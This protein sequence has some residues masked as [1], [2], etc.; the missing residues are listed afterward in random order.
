MLKVLVVVNEPAVRRGIILGMDWGKMEC[1]VAAEAA[2]GLEGLEAA[3][4]YRPNLII[5]DLRMPKMDGLEMFCRLREQGYL[6]NG[7]LLDSGEELDGVEN[8]LRLGAVDFLPKPFQEGDLAAVIES[9]RQRDGTPA[10]LSKGDKRR[11]VLQA[12]NYIA[13]HYRDTDISISSIAGALGVSE[14]H[15]SH[16]F[17]RETSYTVV[18]YL[19]Q[20][21]IHKAMELLRDCRH[22]VYHVAELV[23]YRDVSYFSSTFKKI[24]G[25]PPSAYQRESCRN[26]E[27][28]CRE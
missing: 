18:S 3:E 8:A 28:Q 15:L 13:Q 14:G 7:I 16:V 2:N 26:G 24:T 6:A 4:R 21:R 9:I 10:P 12:M 17:K 19:T 1:V 20:Y 5:T 11:Y 23:G 25:L 27:N 22:K